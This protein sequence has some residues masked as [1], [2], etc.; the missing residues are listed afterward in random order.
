MVAAAAPIAKA[1]ETTMSTSP[2][3][4]RAAWRRTIGSTRRPTTSSSAIPPHASTPRS[5]R[6]T[7]EPSG[8]ASLATMPA[9]PA[10]GG[11]SISIAMTARSWTT[12]IARLRRPLMRCTWRFCWRMRIT[13]AVDERLKAMATTRA[14]GPGAP[15]SSASGHSTSTVAR[16]E[17]E[18][19]SS[20][21]RRLPRSTERLKCMPM[22]NISSTIDS[23]A[24][25]RR[26]SSDPSRPRASG[27]K[28]IDVIPGPMRA[29]V[30]R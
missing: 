12:R 27:P 20:R 9:H 13:T 23:D 3:P 10:M 7:T 17:P 16:I 14:S 22:P 21:L 29:P 24:S 30:M 28:R 25:S 19:A 2:E 1:T 11:S 4:V 8:S 5:S 26:F 18:A 15:A 6:R